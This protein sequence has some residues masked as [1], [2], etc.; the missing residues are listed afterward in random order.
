MSSAI[1]EKYDK[2][3]IKYKVLNGDGSHEFGQSLHFIN[4]IPIIHMMEKPIIIC[5]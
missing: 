1:A 5:K 4:R 2:E 3:P